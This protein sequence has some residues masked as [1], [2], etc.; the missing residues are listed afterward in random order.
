ML[1]DSK[2]NKSMINRV[3]RDVIRQRSTHVISDSE[4]NDPIILM[5]VNIVEH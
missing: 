1:S 5:R 3:I 2:L 4:I